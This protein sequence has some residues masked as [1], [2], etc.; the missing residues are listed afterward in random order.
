MKPNEFRDAK[1]IID[2]LSKSKAE[3]A[4]EFERRVVSVEEI[5]K[6][7]VGGNTF[8]SFRGMP[9]KPSVVFRN[10]ASK[11]LKES[12]SGLDGLR[13]QRDYDDWLRDFSSTFRR[14]W[15]KQMGAAL[16]YG[17][18]RKLPDLLLKHFVWWSGL[19]DDQRR[20]LISFL[21]VPLDSFTLV[22]IRNCI[23]DPEIPVDATMKFVAGP[24]MYNQ[25]QDAIRE[26]TDRAKVPAIYFDVLAWRNM[27]G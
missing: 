24:T 6:V 22:G 23:A 21:H 5:A 16:L 19:T 1:D 11:A 18:S 3:I 2:R 12:V 14:N 9:E 25:V 27:K 13:S 20:R 10:W 26:I 4:T 8:R 17:P 15:Q 7:S